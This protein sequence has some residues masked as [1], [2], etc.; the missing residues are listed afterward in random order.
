MLTLF[1]QSPSVNVATL[2]DRRHVNL[3][4]GRN[5]ARARPNTGRILRGIEA[6]HL[7][8]HYFRW[9][10]MMGTGTR[11]HP[12][13]PFLELAYWIGP[14]PGETPNPQQTTRMNLNS[15]RD[16]ANG[17]HGED[18]WIMMHIHFDPN[19]P[20]TWREENGE[21]M[22][23]PKSMTRNDLT[24]SRFSSA[25]IAFGS[26]TA[27]LRPWIRKQAEAPTRHAL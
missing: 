7:S 8:L 18:R 21:V 1:H 23:V 9:Q 5:N 24:P 4:Y 11:G 13:G 25:R 3:F 14:T 27:G 26:S 22:A 6:G 20:G 12:P 19:N 16:T 2:I 17:Q 15:Y 10:H